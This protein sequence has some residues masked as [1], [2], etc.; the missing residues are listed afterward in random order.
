[1]A[2]IWLGKVR[3]VLAG[4]L[5]VLAAAPT[6]WAQLATGADMLFT[7][8]A[9]DGEFFRSPD[10]QVTLALRMD[11][12]GTLAI[13]TMTVT[14][15]SPQGDQEFPVES[16]EQLIYDPA[17]RSFRATF[18]RNEARVKSLDGM[19]TLE[20]REFHQI[21]GFKGTL[22]F[23][24]G[25]T[26]PVTLT[27]ALNSLTGKPNCQFDLFA[28]ANLAS[29]TLKRPYEAAKPDWLQPIAAAQGWTVLR[30]RIDYIRAEEE[31]DILTGA[32]RELQ[33]LDLIRTLPDVACISFGADESDGAEMMRIVAI[34]RGTLMREAGLADVAALKPA[35]APAFAGAAVFDIQRAGQAAEYALS[36]RAPGRFFGMTQFG[37]D[38][39]VVTLR[40]LPGLAPTG[41]GDI[42]EMAR[43][44]VKS[45]G[46]M[47]GQAEQPVDFKALGPNS[48]DVILQEWLP[49]TTDA[50]AAALGG[51]L[52]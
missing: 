8:K 24:S 28:G 21:R 1:M 30:R 3:A 48:G 37:N 33:A 44:G 50:I 13:A 19:L 15:K 42:R 18:R 29:V 5:M 32:G 52:N 46:R 27:G 47:V 14:V 49:R 39:F 23:E 9:L 26:L 36:V 45:V 2:G 10:N 38:V 34:P 35:L 11:P 25:R 4:A 22:A 12:N 31:Y 16:V 6:A 17:A 43:V 41:S 51:T 40:L 7:V 20:A